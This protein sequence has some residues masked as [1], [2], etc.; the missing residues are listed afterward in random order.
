MTTLLTLMEHY[1]AYK[2]LYEIKFHNVFS[3]SDFKKAICKSL[4]YALVYFFI[5][6]LILCWCM[7]VL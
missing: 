5:F 2:N 3:C 1:V 4:A 7:L 6:T